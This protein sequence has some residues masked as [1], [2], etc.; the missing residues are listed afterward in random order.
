MTETPGLK[1]KK[2]AMKDGLAHFVKNA[3]KNYLGDGKAVASLPA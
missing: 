2:P 1:G 3:A